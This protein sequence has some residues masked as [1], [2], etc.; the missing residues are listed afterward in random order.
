MG[1]YEFMHWQG[2]LLSRDL[3]LIGLDQR[4]VLRSDPVSDTDPLDEQLLADDCE[5]IPRSRSRSSASVSRPARSP[6]ST[7]QATSPSSSRPKSTPKQ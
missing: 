3:L 5:A 6:R 1:S 4:G 2:E 7:V